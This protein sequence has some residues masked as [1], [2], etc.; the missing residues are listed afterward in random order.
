M[1]V[2]GTDTHYFEVTTI[3]GRGV[4]RKKY[5]HKLHKSGLSW[6][7]GLATE[8]DNLVCMFGPKL[9]EL[10]NELS[11]YQ[12]HVKPFLRQSEKVLTDLGFAHDDSVVAT[13]DEGLSSTERT[14][15][16]NLLARHEGLN[17]RFKEFACILIQLELG[18]M[19]LLI[20]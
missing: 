12:S 15:S 5:S 9:A 17:G 3:F 8:N 10:G 14:R 1:T 2:D 20:T 19:M 16:R 13:F 11:Y 6:L 7:L 18:M 4:N